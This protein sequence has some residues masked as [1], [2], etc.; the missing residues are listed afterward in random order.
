MNQ[1]HLT[2]GRAK[3]TWIL[4][5]IFPTPVAPTQYEIQ[6]LRMNPGLFYAKVEPLRITSTYWWVVIYI[7]P[8]HLQAHLQF[9]NYM[10]DK[11]T[12]AKFK[13]ADPHCQI[14]NLQHSPRIKSKIERDRQHTTA[15]K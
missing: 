14:R 8:Q 5:A 13:K 7:D 4:I 12:L 10:T 11:I 1:K 15:I 9:K 6:P 3:W 2:Q